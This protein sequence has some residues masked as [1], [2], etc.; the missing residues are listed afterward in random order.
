MKNDASTK[1]HSYQQSIDFL[2][3]VLNFYIIVSY[4]IYYLTLIFFH[5]KHLN[6]FIFN[7]SYIFTGKF[8]SE[9]TS[10]YSVRGFRT[11]YYSVY[12]SR[13]LNTSFSGQRHGFFCLL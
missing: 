11:G 2:M 6:A 4:S 1:S 10:S 13:F 7:R 12:C 9:C 3:Y 8:L 5:K